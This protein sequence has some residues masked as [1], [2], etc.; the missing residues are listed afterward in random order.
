VQHR[1]IEDPDH[2]GSYTIKLYRSEKSLESDDESLVNTKI[3]LNPDSQSSSYEP[4]VIEDPGQDLVV[5]GEFL[6]VI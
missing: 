6:A 4:L 1:E 2:G 5:V 3:T